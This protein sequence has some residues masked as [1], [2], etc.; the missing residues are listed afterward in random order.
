MEDFLDVQKFNMCK[1]CGN[2][3]ILGRR[4]K[5]VCLDFSPEKRVVGLEWLAHSQDLQPIDILWEILK[6][7]KWKQTA[8]G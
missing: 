1:L 2:D 7:P 5:K 6:Q 8:L 4:S 3:E